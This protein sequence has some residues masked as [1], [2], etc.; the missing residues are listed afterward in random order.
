MLIT[1]FAGWFM[2]RE[3]TSSELGDTG[4]V[5]T[6]WR[7]LARFVAPVGVLFVLADATGLLERIT[8]S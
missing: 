3:S 1:V 6:L 8:G 7:F 4:V 5:Y 2:S